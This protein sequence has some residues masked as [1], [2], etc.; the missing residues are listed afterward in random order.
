M[1]YRISS[2]ESQAVDP[3]TLFQELTVSESFQASTDETIVEGSSLQKLQGC[4]PQNNDHGVATNLNEF[5]KKRK[6]ANDN[7][8]ENE[9]LVCQFFTDQKGHKNL[10]EIVQILS[11]QKA[12][13]V[14][15]SHRKTCIIFTSLRRI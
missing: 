7:K 10:R 12:Q 2:K 14:K 6:Q 11:F 8:Y 13:Q 15:E 9:H 1:R 5:T 3:S 4:G